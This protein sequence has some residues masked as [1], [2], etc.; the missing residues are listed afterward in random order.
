MMETQIQDSSTV[1]P[2]G[3]L[4]PELRSR[5]SQIRAICLRYPV[6]SLSA[7][8]SAVT[9]RFE[10]GRSDI[11]LLVEMKDVS[12]VDYGNAYFSLLGELEDMFTRPV[13]LVT[14]ASL[15]NPF[16]LSNVEETKVILYDAR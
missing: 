12:P 6:R 4:A 11:D 16:I 15:T 13:D 8:G 2:T 7:F 9:G 10:P 5:I 14:A 3:E 1:R